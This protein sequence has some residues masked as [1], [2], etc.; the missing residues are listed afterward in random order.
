MGQ[1]DRR[2]FRQVVIMLWDQW[3][4][5]GKIWILKVITWSHVTV[6]VVSDQYKSEVLF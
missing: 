1:E 6:A 3:H 5:G 2:S 4:V